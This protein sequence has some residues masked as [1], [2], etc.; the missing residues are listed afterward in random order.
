MAN[1][2][3][4]GCLPN[5]RVPRVWAYWIPMTIF[6]SVLFLMALAKTTYL[7]LHENQQTPGLMIVLLRDSVVSFGG[8]LTWIIVNLVLWAVGRVSICLL[9]P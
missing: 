6:E 7:F 5:N 3:I 8:V 4:P 1:W 2:P 9:A